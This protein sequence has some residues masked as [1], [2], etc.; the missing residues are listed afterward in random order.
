MWYF[1]KSHDH[2]SFSTAV[3]TLYSFCTLSK[4]STVRLVKFFFIKILKLSNRT[5]LVG[6]RPECWSSYALRKAD[7]RSSSL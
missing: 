2:F 4:E 5:K 7:P 6:C 1:L 3:I